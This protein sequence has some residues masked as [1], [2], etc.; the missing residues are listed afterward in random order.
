[1]GVPG[2]AQRKL[3]GP[4]DALF[5]GAKVTY[6][7]PQVELSASGTRVGKGWCRPVGARDAKP[8]G[9]GVF[10]VNPFGGDFTHL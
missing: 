8:W 4:G 7:L 10:G 9:L 1:M 2:P 3:A 6:E 5:S